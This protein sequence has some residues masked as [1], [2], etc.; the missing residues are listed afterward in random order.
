MREEGRALA[1]DFQI[2][3]SDQQGPI[4]GDYSCI[5]NI[6]RSSML[7]ELSNL[8]VAR[9]FIVRS[10]APRVNCN[11]ARLVTVTVFKISVVPIRQGP[12]Q[13]L[14]VPSHPI[15]CPRPA[16][17][18]APAGGHPFHERHPPHTVGDLLRTVRQQQDLRPRCVPRL[19]HAL[20]QD[21][22]PKS[23][24]HPLDD[25]PHP[26][27]APHVQPIEGVVQH[28]HLRLGDQR[29]NEEDASYLSGAERVHVAV[30]QGEHA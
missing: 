22:H 12:H 16:P 21:V 28:E 26:L 13:V 18:A 4:L 15:L 8:C 19:T 9:K 20:H 14:P 7:P 11:L 23:L 6:P 3:G 5:A 2:I 30:E 10:N 24:Q 29:P 25:V 17:A 27:P 1:N